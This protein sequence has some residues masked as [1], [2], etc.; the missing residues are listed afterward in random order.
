[1][2]R[3]R[4]IAGARVYDR[5]STGTMIKRASTSLERLRGGSRYWISDPRPLG[6]RRRDAIA[7]D[8]DRLQRRLQEIQRGLQPLADQ[9]G[10]LTAQVEYALNTVCWRCVGPPAHI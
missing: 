4:D 3:K 7:C 1:M 8:L 10:H 6:S 9:L 2:R 5:G